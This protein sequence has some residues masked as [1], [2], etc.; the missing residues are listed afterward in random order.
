VVEKT[1][2]WNGDAVTMSI[3]AQFNG[4]SYP[5]DQINGSWHIDRNS[6]TYVESSQNSAIG[7]KTMRLDKE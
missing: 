7:V 1:G 4:A 5:L 3:S 2:T 6:W